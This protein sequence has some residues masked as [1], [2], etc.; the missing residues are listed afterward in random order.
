L[1]G[2]GEVDANRQRRQGT[3]ANNLNIGIQP[4]NQNGLIPSNNV[5]FNPSN[6]PNVNQQQSN[7]NL[8]PS[9]QGQ[10]QPVRSLGYYNSPAFKPPSFSGEKP[11][12][13]FDTQYQNWVSNQNSQ[14]DPNNMVDGKNSP[15]S[16]YDE[17]I[18]NF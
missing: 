6:N 17:I 9:S 16:R 13:W 2:Q 3:N 4:G 10:A 14:I 5:Q 18:I 8:L 15:P 7:N 1:I 11:V 12:G